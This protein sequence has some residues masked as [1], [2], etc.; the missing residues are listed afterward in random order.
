MRAW[1][2]CKPLGPSFEPIMTVMRRLPEQKSRL[3]RIGSNILAVGAFGLLAAPAAILLSNQPDPATRVGRHLW[4]G[5]L[6]IACFAVLEVI[7]ALIPLRRGEGWAL[8][9]AAVSFVVVGAPVLVLD[10][11]YVPEV[12]LVWTLAPQ[13]MGQLI[14]IAGLF[15]CGVGI[16]QRSKGNAQNGSP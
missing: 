11:S 4:A 7:L 14:G 2:H 8:W 9:T 1:I 6:A 16:H 5:A 13:L 12:T 3:I 10:A 15:L